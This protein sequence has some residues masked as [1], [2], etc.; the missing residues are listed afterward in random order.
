MLLQREHG[1]PNRLE[2]LRPNNI[3]RSAAHPCIRWLCC[4]FEKVSK[5]CQKGF[6]KVSKRCQKGV[7]KVSK[8]CQSRLLE[9]LKS[10]AHADQEKFRSHASANDFAS[11][12][13]VAPLFPGR[14]TVEWL[15]VDCTSARLSRFVEGLLGAC[16]PTRRPHAQLKSEIQNCESKCRNDSTRNCRR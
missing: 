14:A 7:K 6:E 3:P 15:K 4:G 12:E 16:R 9:N 1:A 8:R 5:R 11:S 13:S 2:T 10:S